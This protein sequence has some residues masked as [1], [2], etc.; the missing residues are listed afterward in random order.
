M[1]LFSR[2][3]KEYV[4]EYS[5]EAD[6]Q[7]MDGVGLCGHGKFDEAVT[8]FDKILEFEPNH[9]EVLILKGH[10]LGQLGKFDEAVIAYDKTIDVDP[11]YGDAWYNKSKALKYLDRN[12]EAKKCFD[13]AEEL[14]YNA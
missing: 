4:G 8:L 9:T 1:G 10:A 5:K 3:K 11:D 13:K 12:E 14:G 7:Y 6:D 2:K